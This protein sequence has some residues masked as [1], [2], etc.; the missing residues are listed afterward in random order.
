MLD[1]YLP[2]YEH[3]T[4]RLLLDKLHVETS[5]VSALSA[6]S[7]NHPGAFSSGTFQFGGGA[8]IQSV[9]YLLGPRRPEHK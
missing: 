5:N 4:K 1:S 6:I 8:R 9:Q 3:R 2:D 7:P